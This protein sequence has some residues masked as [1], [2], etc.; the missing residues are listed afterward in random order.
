MKIDID[1]FSFKVKKK[2]S[3]MTPGEIGVFLKNGLNI[4][5]E[6][7]PMILLKGDE[8]VVN[9]SYL[10]SD[11][12]FQDTPDEIVGILDS[13]IKIMI[14]KK[15]YPNRKMKASERDL[16]A[17]SHENK[18][19]GT[20]K[21]KLK[22]FHEFIDMKS[23]ICDEVDYCTPRFNSDKKLIEVDFYVKEK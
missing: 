6:S 16:K 3:D 10:G 15:I 4:D 2:I 1:D 20:I 21:V 17:F 19:E 12:I 5:D 11:F 22:E 13:D 23:P 7:D 8:D 9:L 14:S 18:I